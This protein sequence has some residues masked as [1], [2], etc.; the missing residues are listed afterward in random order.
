M[1]PSIAVAVLML[2][3][4]PFAAGAA[5][6]K[7]S[8][9]QQLEAFL[10]SGGLQP[11]EVKGI[12]LAYM[13]P[14]ASLKG[15][16]KIMFTSIQVSFVRDFG[17]GGAGRTRVSPAEMQRIRERLTETLREEAT[18]E[19][20]KSGYQVVDA[21]GDDVLAI[22]LG[23]ANLN[24][25]A[26]DTMAN[27]GVR[28][29]ALSAGEMTLVSEISDSQSGEVLVRAY[30]REQADESITPRRITLSENRMEAKAIAREWAKILRT[31]LD[32]ANTAGGAAPAP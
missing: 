31:Q 17:R 24:I 2:A 30:D 11:V 6:P 3:T 27:A 25:T 18:A 32:L 15:Y 5:D 28:I 26:P 9:A 13:R 8:A 22:D 21:P 29:F 23:I 16:R 19:L 4:L 12:D 20:A 7:P 14:D 1:K 10:T